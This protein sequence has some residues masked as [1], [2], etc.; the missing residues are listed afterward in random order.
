MKPN[1]WIKNQKT[2]D[3]W[4]ACLNER[5]NSSCWV[6]VIQS[7]QSELNYFCCEKVELQAVQCMPSHRCQCWFTYTISLLQSVCYLSNWFALSLGSWKFLSI[8]FIKFI[9]LWL[10]IWPTHNL[11]A[12]AQDF[13]IY[14]TFNCDLTEINNISTKS[15]YIWRIDVVDKVNHN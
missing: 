6:D 1:N 7:V 5:L 4:C 11:P 12:S 2:H 13:I 14:F 3:S 15:T 8:K 10:R 9:K